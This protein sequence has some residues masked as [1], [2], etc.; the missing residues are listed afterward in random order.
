MIY[1]SKPEM[2]S[3]CCLQSFTVGLKGAAGGVMVT[4]SHNPKEDNGYKVYWH[5]GAQVRPQT[6]QII[7]TS[8][9]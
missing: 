8:M 2:R 7:A 9:L 3:G 5:T 6:Q 4:A 1:V